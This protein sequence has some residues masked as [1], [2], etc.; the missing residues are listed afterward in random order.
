MQREIGKR[1]LLTLELGE[2]LNY[3]N[4]FNY[5]LYFKDNRSLNLENKLNFINK[6]LYIV[7]SG[8]YEIKDPKIIKKFGINVQFIFRI[9]DRTKQLLQNSEQ[10]NNITYSMKKRINNSFYSMINFFGNNFFNI[11]QIIRLN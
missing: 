5:Y 8:C 9:D 4:Y 1:M 11:N 6:F 3:K 10:K 2:K 7:D